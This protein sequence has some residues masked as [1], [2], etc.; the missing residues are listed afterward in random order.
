MLVQILLY[1]AIGNI[2]FPVGGVFLLLN[3]KASHRMIY[4]LAALEFLYIATSDII[5]DTYEENKKGFAVFESV[6]LILGIVVMYIAVLV[7][8]GSH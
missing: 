2:I 3:N 6:L 4:G 8:E 5:P 1:T 7:L